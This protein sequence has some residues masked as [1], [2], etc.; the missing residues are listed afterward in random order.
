MAA[1]VRCF[2]RRRLS[3]VA[4]S[5]L[6][7]GRVISAGDRLLP[8]LPAENAH[9]GDSQL[10]QPAAGSSQSQPGAGVTPIQGPFLGAMVQP[11]QLPLSLLF[12]AESADCKRDHSL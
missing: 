2:L 3:G 8:L 10:Q 6:L 4:E 9:G 12:S 1:G 7:T 5:E 11:P